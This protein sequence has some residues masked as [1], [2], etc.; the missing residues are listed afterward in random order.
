[1]SFKFFPL[2]MQTFYTTVSN[3]SSITDSMKVFQ[4]NILCSVEYIS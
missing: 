2:L 4:M 1:M 3:I